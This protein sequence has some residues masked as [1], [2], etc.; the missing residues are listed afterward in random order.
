MASDK[1]GRVD[2]D[3]LADE[4]SRIVSSLESIKDQ[5]ILANRLK[6]DEIARSEQVAPAAVGLA[7][8]TNSIL[9]KH[10]RV[11]SGKR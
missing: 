7:S 11:V 4:V 9:Y 1:S 5:L 6:A 10:W 8:E 2:I 3:M